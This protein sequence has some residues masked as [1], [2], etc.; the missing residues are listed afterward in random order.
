MTSGEVKAPTRVTMICVVLNGTMQMMVLSESRTIIVMILPLLVT[1]RG[2]VNSTRNWLSFR[3]KPLSGRSLMARQRSTRI[4]SSLW[5]N[6][7]Q[8]IVICSQATKL[9]KT[10][11]VRAFMTNTTVSMIL[12]GVLDKNYKLSQTMIRLSKCVSIKCF[13]IM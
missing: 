3:K 7:W 10:T 12:M 13:D 1:S 8:N 6:S 5:R 2:Y 4:D 9:V 11:L